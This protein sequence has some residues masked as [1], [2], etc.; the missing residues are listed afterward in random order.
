VAVWLNVPLVPLIVSVLVPMGVLLFVVIVSVELHEGP[1]ADLGLKLAVERAGN[2][3]T[4][5]LT[6][7][8]NPLSGVTVTVMLTFE[9]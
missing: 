1:V 9:P 4:L 6:L 7:P 8:A 5:K 3:V 2:P